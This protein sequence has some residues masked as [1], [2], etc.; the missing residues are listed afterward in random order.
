MKARGDVRPQIRFGIVGCAD[1]AWRAM[2]PALAECD[3]IELVAVASRTKDKA[4]RFA[5]SLNCEGIVGY[6]SLLRRD[7]IDAVYIP[8]P[9]GLRGNGCR[10]RLEPANMCLLRSPLPWILSQ[11]KE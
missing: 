3:E 1:I 6:H 7:D 8:L 10:K 2:G 5:K 11:Q 4:D 9:T